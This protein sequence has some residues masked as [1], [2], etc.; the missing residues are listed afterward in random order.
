MN[1]AYIIDGIRTPIGKLKG[2]LS[3]VRPDDMAAFVI[4]KLLE[5]NINSMCG[6]NPY[7]LLDIGI[8]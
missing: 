7:L 8:Y 6:I 4:K 2:S 3:S 5:R 1:N